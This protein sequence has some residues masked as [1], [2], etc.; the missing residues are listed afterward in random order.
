LSLAEVL[1]AGLA[2][3]QAP[4]LSPHHWKVLNALLTCRTPQLGGHRYRCEH[5]GREHFVPRS[6]GNRHCPNCQYQQA[7]EWLQ[8][9]EELLLPIPYFHVVFTL[10]HVLN[11]LIQQN[12]AALYQLLF[13]AA[14]QTLLE[15]G[16]NNLG[17]QLGVTLVLHTWSQTLL[18]H[19]HVHCIVT[20]GG[21]A[22]AG[23]A[24]KGTQQGFLFPVA[25]L[26]KV[27]Q[28]KFCE[29]LQKLQADGKLQF[30]GQLANLAQTAAFQGLI[31]DATLK[32]W[33]VYA[34]RPFAGPEQVLKYLSA[35]THRVALSQRRLLALSTDTGKVKFAYKL[36]RDPAPPLWTDMELDLPE[37]V[38]RFCLHILPERFVKI[39]HYGL[40]ANRG[41]QER[42]AQ[43]RA[44]LTS[45]A[46]AQPKAAPAEEPQP[47]QAGEDDPASRLVCPYCGHRAL[48]WIETVDPPAR[49]PPPGS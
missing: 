16:R 6:C 30:H 37:F 5:C 46:T 27:F 10:P 33:N 22:L 4:Q 32:S 2:S 34:K 49:A 15:F 47:K 26:A 39:R 19:Y 12:R 36:R 48:V 24:W 13:W 35:Y 18:D 28:G 17:A 23:G 1:R 40:L 43:A 21:L 42:V 29:K 31:R 41:R 11:P 14:A 45:A 8:R 20:G 25:A 7:L 44:L 9:Q 3:P 38:R